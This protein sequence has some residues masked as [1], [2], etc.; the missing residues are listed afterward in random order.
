MSEIGPLVRQA[1]SKH[2]LFLPHA[3][4]QMARPERRIRRAEVEQVIMKGTVIEDYPEDPRGHSC[5]MLGYGLHDRPIHVVCAPKRDYLA[6]VTAYLPDS[7]Q[8]EDDFRRRK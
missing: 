3:V 2:I 8:W 5:L 4:Q 7:N 1:A 6:V